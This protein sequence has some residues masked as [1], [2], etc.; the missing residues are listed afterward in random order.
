MTGSCAHVFLRA[1]EVTAVLGV[2][3][4][5]TY[6]LIG[7]GELEAVRVSP[8]GVRVRESVLHARTCAHIRR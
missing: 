2:S 8:R 7:S 5:T 4:R 6:R 1:R 3:R